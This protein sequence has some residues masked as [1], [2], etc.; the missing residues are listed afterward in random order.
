MH[1]RSPQPYNDTGRFNGNYWDMP[2]M[3]SII[4]LGQRQPPKKK[5]VNSRPY[6]NNIIWPCFEKMTLQWESISTANQC[7]RVWWRISRLATFHDLFAKLINYK[8]HFALTQDR[9]SRLTRRMRWHLA[10]TKSQVPK[11][12]NISICCNRRNRRLY[13]H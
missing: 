9:Y 2:M 4:R 8:A 11:R 5:L 12:K 1:L 13:A 3:I 10:T 7:S 6:M